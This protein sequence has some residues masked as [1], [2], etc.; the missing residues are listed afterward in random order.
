MS[1]AA[2]IAALV[3][4]AR[5][6]DGR[7]DAERL[8]GIPEVYAAL[9]RLEV[10]ADVDARLRTRSGLSLRAAALGAARRAGLSANT[11]R[12]L[13][14][15]RRSGQLLPAA[16]DQTGGGPTIDGERDL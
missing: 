7:V 9:L 14:L 2:D 15:A 11:I 12:N 5:A 4:Q 1:L 10:L 8:A 6:G 13:W 16:L 3:V